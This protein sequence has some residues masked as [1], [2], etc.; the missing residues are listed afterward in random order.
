MKIATTLSP[1]A[2]SLTGFA[3]AVTGAGPWT[4]TATVSG[5]GLAHTVTIQNNTATNHSGKT[6]TIT[7]LDPNG[8]AQTE[9]LAGPGVSATVTSVRFFSKVT[10]VSI[11]ATIGADTFNIGWA[12][13]A[14]SCDILLNPEFDYLPVFQ[15]VISGTI[16]FD[17]AGTLVDQPDDTYA[18]VVFANDANW[19]A[20]T[21]SVGP[22]A[23]ALRYRRARVEINTYTATPTFKLY[24]AI[25][26]L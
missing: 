13:A 16:N 1:A 7:G 3:A 19:T 2:V 14:V 17:I 6:V 12:Q 20:K 4:P 15:A 11:S 10:Q 24:A 8:A 9:A 25:P 22:T 26:G 5:D 21:A 18:S 23:L